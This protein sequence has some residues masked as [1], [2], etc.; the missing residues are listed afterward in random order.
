VLLPLIGLLIG[1]LIGT[2][3]PMD[4]PMS[5]SSYMAIALLA[6]LDSVFGGISADLQGKF[7]KRIFLSGFFGNTI[8]AA[9]LTYIGDRLGIPIYYAAIFTFGTRLFQN[10]AKIRRH[11]IHREKKED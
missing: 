5:Y 10:F 4:I 6:A 9:L 3:I 8:L 2:F 7:D 11:L 1:L